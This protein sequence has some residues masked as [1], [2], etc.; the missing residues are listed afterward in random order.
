MTDSYLEQI[1]LLATKFHNAILKFDPN[2]RL[3]SFRD[4]PVGSCCDATDLLGTYFLEK[5]LGSFDFVKGNRGEKGNLETH[6]WLQKEDIIV[7]ITAYQFPEIDKEV[8]VTTDSQWYSSAFQIVE[9]RTA[10]CSYYQKHNDIWQTM[11]ENYY[12][13][14]STID[15]NL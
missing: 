6:A 2:D 1:R 3:C 12:Y 14:V 15:H 4:F 13:I 10:G 7:D 9:R 11:T 5:G 8:I